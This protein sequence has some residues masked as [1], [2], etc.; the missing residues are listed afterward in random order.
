[1]PILTNPEIASAV[2]VLQR[3]VKDRQDALNGMD[4]AVQ[5][6]ESV[7]KA[8]EKQAKTAEDPSICNQVVAVLE[9]IIAEVRQAA[10]LVEDAWE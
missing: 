1:M 9:P 8:A 10:L 2:Q 4:S 6:L 7:Q 3:G 5:L